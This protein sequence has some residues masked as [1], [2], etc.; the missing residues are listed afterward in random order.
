M[1]HE[2]ISEGNE[3]K[4]RV[5]SGRIGTRLRNGLNWRIMKQADTDGTGGPDQQRLMHYS[6]APGMWQLLEEDVW[7]D[8]T[9]QTPGDIDRHV[10][11]VWGHS[12]GRY[13]DDI[14]MRRED[15]AGDSGPDGDYDD[16]GDI[17]RYYLT[18]AQFTPVAI[19]DDGVHVIERIS[20]ISCGEARHHRMAD[21][22][23]D[24]QTETSDSFLLQGNWGNFGTGDLDRSGAVGSAD[25][26]L[27]CVK[28]ACP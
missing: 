14:T 16:T 20:H 26:I 21:L 2:T 4:S 11:Y 23:G 1:R 12:G 8:W 22:D 27:G 17:T 10:Q 18:D 3:G 15:R 6:D 25:L 28:R 19:I 24:V 5:I 9:E 7:D 13:I